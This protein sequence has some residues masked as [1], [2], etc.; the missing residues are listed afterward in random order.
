[1]WIIYAAIGSLFAALVTIFAKFGLQKFDPTFT[2]TVRAVIMTAILLVVYLFSHKNSVS[3]FSGKDWVFVILSGIAGAISWVFY[4]L[5]LK[6]GPATKV[7]VIDRFSVVLIA[8]LA[9][10]F[11]REPLGPKN[12]FGII[13]VFI[14]ILFTLAK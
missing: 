5:A 7:A 12:I 6:Y 1:M 8:V 4:F 13:L 2:T 10:F 3:D 9:A 11:L 14:G